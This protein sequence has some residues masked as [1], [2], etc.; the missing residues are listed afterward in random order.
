MKVLHIA[1]THLGYT[2]YRKVTT[3]G[4]NQR[5]QDT[6]LA[7]QQ[8]IDYAIKQKPDVVLHAGDLFD[9]VRPTNRAISV[10]LNQIL[11]L[12]KNNIPFV[13]VDGNHERPKLA[14]TGHIFNIFNHIEHVY[15]VYEN[16]YESIMIEND[17]EILCIHAVPQC[18]SKEAFEKLIQTV[19]PNPD[20]HYNILL[21]HGS[22]KGIKELSMNEFNEVYIPPTVLKDKYSY[23]AL[24]HYH[25]FTEVQ[26]NVV[27]AGSPERFTFTDARQEKGFVEIHLEKTIT[28]QFHP[29][30]IRAMIDAPSVQCKGKTVADI[31][32]EIKK[33]IH[34]LEPDTKI[35]RITLQE[36]PPAVYRGLDFQEIKTWCKQSIHFELKPQMKESLFNSAH[37]STKIGA[38]LQEFDAFLTTQKIKEEHT[39]K[40]LGHHYLENIHAKQEET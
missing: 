28:H 1:D 39:I 16:K 2:A 17:K 23:I 11:R 14:E 30:C 3:D 37:Q 19:K 27:Y 13:I 9:S 20:A 35:I 10:A 12:S 31:M 26:K 4:I 8:I 5:E 22:V 7:F 33:T 21:A 29:L 34:A 15:P 40:S 36:I 25:T 6:Y 18:S 32:T 38:L 24:G